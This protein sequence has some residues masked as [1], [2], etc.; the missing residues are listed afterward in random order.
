M[1][2]HQWNIESIRPI[3]TTCIEVF[4]ASRCMFGSNFP[5]DKL[6]KSYDEI[7]QSYETLA[8][9]YSVGEQERLFSGTAT[10]FYRLS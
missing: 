2:N 10:D 3:V 9:G 7:W 4:G 1:F 6:H 8:T 5:V